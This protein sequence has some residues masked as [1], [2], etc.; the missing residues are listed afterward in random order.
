MSAAS[1]HIH[2]H[3]PRKYFCTSQSYDCTER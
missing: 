3:K 1:K 2:Q